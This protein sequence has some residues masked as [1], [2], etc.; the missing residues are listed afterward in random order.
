MY[1]R[2]KCSP[3]LGLAQDLARRGGDV[4][5]AEQHELGQMR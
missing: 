1:C 3:G 2:A 4:A 5:F